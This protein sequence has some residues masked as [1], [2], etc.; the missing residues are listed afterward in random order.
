M[1]CNVW[2]D[3]KHP[4][5]PEQT[6]ETVMDAPNQMPTH[7]FMPVI[8]SCWHL[9]DLWPL[10]PASGLRRTP[11]TTQHIMVCCIG[12][13]TQKFGNQAL[14]ISKSAKLSANLPNC[15]WPYCDLFIDTEKCQTDL[16][17]HLCSH[18]SGMRVYISNQQLMDQCRRYIYA[19]KVDLT[20]VIDL[21]TRK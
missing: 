21:T 6:P 19:Y 20:T 5:H 18:Q 14:R 15:F 2:L 12:F 8:S 16:F 17:N 9:S 7:Y 11:A 4:P 13:C 1:Q 10:Q 3:N